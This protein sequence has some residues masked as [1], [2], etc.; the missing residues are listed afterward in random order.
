MQ[1]FTLLGLASLAA[2]IPF[3]ISQL[4]PPLHVRLEDQGNSK[5]KAVVI[6]RSG[7]NIN[8]L[9]AGSLL[10]TTHTEKVRVYSGGKLTIS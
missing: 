10:D 4:A 2:A 6:N 8:V 9:K 3:K 7:S 1:F 5:V